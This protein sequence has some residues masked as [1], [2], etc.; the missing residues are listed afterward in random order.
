[1]E[2]SRQ[3]IISSLSRARILD[4]NVHGINAKLCGSVPI[5]KLPT[6]REDEEMQ[7]SWNSEKIIRSTYLQTIYNLER[8]MSLGQQEKCSQEVRMIQRGDMQESSVDSAAT[9][10]RS[11]KKVKTSRLS[12]KVLKP[13]RQ[14]YLSRIRCLVPGYNTL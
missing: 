11:A 8:A 2:N 6:I 9:I 3:E 1:M 13:F 12:P 5:L 10:H 14:A 7:W 4:C